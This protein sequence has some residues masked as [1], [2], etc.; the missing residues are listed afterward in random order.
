MSQLSKIY[1]GDSHIFTSKGRNDTI[2]IQT[3]YGETL[4]LG[5]T[6]DIVDLS[7]NPAG[8]LIN[9]IS[10]STSSGGTP[11]TPDTSLQFN[12]SGAFVGS[13]NLTWTTSTN[14]L[15]VAGTISVTTGFASAFTSSTINSTTIS[16]SYGTFAKDISVGTSIVVHYN[17]GLISGVSDPVSNLD[18]VNKQYADAISVATNIN[19]TV[20]H[21]SI[22]EP[23]VEPGFNCVNPTSDTFFDGN[24]FAGTMGIY[25][26]EDDP[27]SAGILVTITFA[28]PYTKPPFVFLSFGQFT[29]PNTLYWK[30]PT[31]TKFEIWCKTAPELGDSF[32]VNYMC[33]ESF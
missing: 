25:L 28:V 11:G 13:S 12:G 9:G 31:T 23:P 26:S 7:G 19:L 32:Y 17:T 1:E 15:T 3:G 8:L 5:G 30:N 21:M 24:D 10:V 20:K 2:I 14:T 16:S 33:L 6:I 18:V 22:W 29:T 27:T 4:Q